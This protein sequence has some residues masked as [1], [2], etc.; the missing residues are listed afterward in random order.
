M[1]DYKTDNLL[2]KHIER[3]SYDHIF[4]S[5]SLSLNQNQKTIYKQ[6]SKLVLDIGINQLFTVLSTLKTA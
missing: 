2:D 5:A 4:A 6:I 3:E 1:Q